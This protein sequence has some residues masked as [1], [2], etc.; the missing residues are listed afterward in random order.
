MLKNSRRFLF[1]L[2]ASL[3]IGTVLMIFISLLCGCGVINQ[4]SGDINKVKTQAYMTE[5]NT[6]THDFGNIINDFQNDIKEK[7]LDNMKNKLETSSK[8]IEEFNKLNPPE[9]CVNV[10]K[11][12]SDAFSLLQQAL[13]TY[14]QIYSDFVNKNFDENIL[15]QRIDDAQKTYNQGVELLNKGDKLALEV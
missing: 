15:N 2:A 5:L 9:S 10:H 8:L 1:K 3:A 6:V 4:N 14:V 7:N 12:Y 13:S 11:T